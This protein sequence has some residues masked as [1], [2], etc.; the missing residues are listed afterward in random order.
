[1][2]QFFYLLVVLA[3][4]A[5]AGCVGDDSAGTTAP[6]APAPVTTPLPVITPTPTPAPVEMAYID[7]M[8][9]AV[10]DEKVT[11]YR[12]M[13]KIRIK[14]GAYDEVQ[15][16]ARY[17]DN[18]TFDSDIVGLGGNNTLVQ[19]FYLFPDLKYQSQVPA[20][21]VRLDTSRYPV[22]MNGTSGIAYVNPPPAPTAGATRR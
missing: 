16:T 18:N 4:L 1:M 13:G 15:V 2:R 17:P 3:V 10:V 12:C 9:C 21:T 11:T 22:V 7:G 6:P 14:S 20:Y 19:P 5:T 8:D